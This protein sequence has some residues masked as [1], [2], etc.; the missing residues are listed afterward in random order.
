ML[1]ASTFFPSIFQNTQILFKWCMA[2]SPRTPRY[3]DRGGKPH[4]Y[5]PDIMV[6]WKR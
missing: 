1:S 3:V 6:G 2:G 4:H 5:V